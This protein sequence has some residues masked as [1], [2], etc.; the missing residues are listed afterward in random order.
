MNM[1]WPGLNITPPADFWNIL[2]CITP[3]ADV[4]Q[5]DIYWN[6]FINLQCYIHR[7]RWSLHQNVQQHTLDWSSYNSHRGTTSLTLMS[8]MTPLPALSW[9]YSPSSP[10]SRGTTLVPPTPPCSPPRHRAGVRWRE[11]M[12]QC[13]LHRSPDR[14]PDIFNTRSI[15]T[16]AIAPSSSAQCFIMHCTMF[17]CTAFNA[18]LLSW[19][20]YSSVTSETGTTLHCFFFWQNQ[21][22]LEIWQTHIKDNSS[23][24]YCLNSHTSIS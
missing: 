20:D 22:A 13:A 21:P 18:L 7:N 23:C 12:P 6:T 10:Q 9:C 11:I 2:L 17:L 14:G 24:Q 4:L 15:H 3:H 8:L 16:C 1:L 5:C 19:T